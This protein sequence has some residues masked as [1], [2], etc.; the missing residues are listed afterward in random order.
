M[1]EMRLKILPDLSRLK[2][3]LKQAVNQSFKSG[4]SGTG[5]DLSG[6]VAKGFVRAT[7]A[8]EA[9]KG[10][11]KK[12]VDASP[13]L[14]KE[15]T[16]L[17]Y[18]L[19][20]LLRPVGDLLATFLR[21]L[22]SAFL[23]FA[24]PFYKSVGKDVKTA[25]GKI[26]GGA[27]IVAGAIAGGQAG[28]AAGTVVP[29]I[30]NV[31][32]AV[33]G[34][35]LGAIV[36]GLT[37]IKVGAYVQE[38]AVELMDFFK[39][40]WRDLV[41]TGQ[42]IWRALGDTGKQIWEDLKATGMQITEELLAM[43][44]QWKE[45]FANF[46]KDTWANMVSKLKMWKTDI[47]GFFDAIEWEEIW[48]SMKTFVKDTIPRWWTNTFNT[49]KEFLLTRIPQWFESMIARIKALIPFLGG[50]GRGGGS[51][52]ADD[53]IL[54]KGGNLI[55]TNPNDTIVGFKGGT[56]GGLDPARGG[57]GATIINHITVQA[58]DVASMEQGVLDDLFMRL[59]QK[60]KTEVLTSTS[61]F[62]FQ[63]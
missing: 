21:P 19:T 34:A 1:A 44:V 11:T 31:A 38:I 37:G 10:F 26:G 20:L 53:F 6:S 7:I 43:L 27:G 2:T 14:Q 29:G 52:S 18:G 12:L 51:E 23:R 57:G 41:A 16:K 33:A 15:M 50:G 3:E 36:G 46:F 8:L 39:Q 49:I 13:L 22:T 61:Q 62:P 40:V 54:T 9:I 60:M 32:G 5:N 42:D 63:G 4:S 28:A 58:L 59:S 17:G 56:P 45:S 25:G 35:I 55:K 48:G 24:V 30:G 47:L